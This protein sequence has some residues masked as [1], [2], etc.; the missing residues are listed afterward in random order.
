M[1][2]VRWPT[3]CWARG[4]EHGRIVWKV[5]WAGGWRVLSRDRRLWE[6]ARWRAY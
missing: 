4:G 6:W 5:D 2:L 3:E 1:S